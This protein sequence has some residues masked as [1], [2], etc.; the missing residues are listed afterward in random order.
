ML[1]VGMQTLMQILLSSAN[2]TAKRTIVLF[3]SKSVRKID[4]SAKTIALS[5]PSPAGGRGLG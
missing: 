1:G 5:T 2:Y 3:F 4:L